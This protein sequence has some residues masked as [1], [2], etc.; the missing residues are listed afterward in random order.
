MLALACLILALACW[1]GTASALLASSGLPSSSWH[2]LG[3]RSDWAY[4]WH[5]TCARA[6]GYCSWVIR[7]RG[8]DSTVYC[9]TGVLGGIILPTM[10]WVA[11]TNLPL[12]VPGRLLF[13][14]K[15]KYIWESSLQVSCTWLLL[16][17][18]L[19][20]L[21]RD[22]QAISWSTKSVTLLTLNQQKH[23]RKRRFSQYCSRKRRFSL[24]AEPPIVTCAMVGDHRVLSSKWPE[25]V[26][27]RVT[28]VLSY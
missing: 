19:E 11:C 7:T 25:Q 23:S 5:G 12:L 16:Y 28:E 17:C 10:R 21:P 4:F 13:T 1:I 15:R 27:K 2:G 8:P 9:A 3:R 20:E 18:T 22:K 24:S 14:T 26:L 6:P